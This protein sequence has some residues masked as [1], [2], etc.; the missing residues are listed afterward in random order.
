D[1]MFWRMTAQ[2]M[3]V[4]RKKTD[5]VPQLIAMVNDQ[6][7]DSLGLNPGALH[8]LWTLDGLGLTGEALAT[9]RKALYHPAASVRRA[10]LQ[11]LPRDSETFN[12]LFETGILPDK[13]SPWTVEYT[14]PTSALSDAD[15]HV[16]LE[17]VLVLSEYPGSPRAAAALTDL[18]LNQENARDPWMPDAV[19]IAGAKQGFGFLTDLVKHQ[20]PQ[21]DSL[22]MSGI[23][24]TIWK[25]SR[26]EAAKAN[27]DNIVALMGML[28]EVPAVS[29]AIL[30]GVE[31][32]WPADK[33][34]QFS[35]EQRL[36]LAAAA[37]GASGELETALGRVAARWQMPDVF[38]TP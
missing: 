36:K 17:G 20:M 29:V 15:A 37:R 2:R 30:N 26:I 31:Q 13:T 7:V 33:P 28:P 8:A 4:E 1:N 14:V 9:A 27:T 32:G 16:R 38:R 21:R 3:L 6:T 34:P 19:A 12:D 22:A 24:R 5:V 10:A 18:I 23:R 11:M 25:L 35:A